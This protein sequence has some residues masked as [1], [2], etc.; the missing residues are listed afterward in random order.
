M[1]VVLKYMI[2]MKETQPKPDDLGCVSCFL[3]STKDVLR[4][5]NFIGID[6]SLTAIPG[7]R[8]TKIFLFEFFQR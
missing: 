2:E 1:Q 6:E 7:K 5:F 4:L 8:Q 3:H